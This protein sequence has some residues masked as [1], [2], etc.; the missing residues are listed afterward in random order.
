[1]RR[2]HEELNCLHQSVI[3]MGCLVEEAVRNA[4][5][6]ISDPSPELIEKVILGDDQIDHIFD[7]VETSCFMMLA[8]QQPVAR[9]LRLIACCIR[10]ISDLE[11]MGD[12]A[13]NIV[14]SS[15]ASNDYQSLVASDILIRMGNAVTEMI[16]ESLQAFTK[17]DA[18]IAETIEEHDER[19]DRM[20]EELFEQLFRC[21]SG[22]DL[23]SAIKSAFIG[24]FLE[25]I[26][27]HCVTVAERINFLVKGSV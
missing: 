25:R 26:A 16:A 10:I 1:M 18:S 27:D 23:R 8:M 6:S 19:I 11:R 7:Q 15:P 5:I 20:Y 3:K 24:R 22:H 4:V 21:E 2:F 13:I 12:L 14:K 17:W 9:D